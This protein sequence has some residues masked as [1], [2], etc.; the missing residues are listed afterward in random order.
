MPAAGEAAPQASAESAQPTMSEGRYWTNQLNACWDRSM[1]D[2]LKTAAQKALNYIENTEGELGMT[3]SC[4]DALRSALAARTSPH[5]SRIDAAARASE[6]VEATSPAKR[7]YAARVMRD[8]VECVFRFEYADRSAFEVMSDN[9]LF[10][11]WP[12]GR[13]EER[14][15]KITSRLTR[16]YGARPAD[17]PQAMAEPTREEIAGHRHDQDGQT[18]PMCGRVGNGEG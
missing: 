11:T 6:T 2:A 9:T 5:P 17:T 3:L 14:R 8:W 18:C 12:S 15:G 7:D 4:G 13:R 1:S 16:F 10:L